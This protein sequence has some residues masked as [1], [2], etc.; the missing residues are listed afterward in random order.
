[1]PLNLQLMKAHNPFLHITKCKISHNNKKK[2]T[3]FQIHIKFD[4][5]IFSESYG[6]FQS[7]SNCNK[8]ILIEHGHNAIVLFAWFR[9]CFW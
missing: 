1:M 2:K 4:V 9:N 5:I 3:N 8:H 6:T 7:S